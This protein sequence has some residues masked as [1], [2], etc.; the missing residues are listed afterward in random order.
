MGFASAR[1]HHC[2]FGRFGQI[3][4]RLVAGAPHTLFTAMDKDSAHVEFVKQFGNRLFYGDLTR[5]DLLRSAG[6]KHAKK[7]LSLQS[8]TSLS[9]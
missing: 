3:I 7:Y 4:G 5:V 6:I 9:P 2:G 1:G 8:M